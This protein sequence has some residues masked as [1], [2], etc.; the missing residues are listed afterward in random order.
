MAAD[1]KEHILDAAERLI[2]EKGI[3]AVSLRSITAAADVNLAAV[4]YHFGSKEG[5]VRKV[6][7]RRVEGLNRDRLA[8][9]TAAEERAG[10]GPLAVEDVLRSLYEPAFRL[11]QQ[12]PDGRMFVRICGRLYAEPA[13]YVQEHVDQ[14]FEQV[15][16]R[17]TAA[18]ERA[19]P[20]VNELDRSWGVHFAVGAMIHT[21]LDSERLKRFTDGVC[22]PA[23]VETAIEEMVRFSAAG[24]RAARPAVNQNEDSDVTESVGAHA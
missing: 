18:F 3:D 14:L 13:A 4:H 23:D 20:G 11:F 22:D 24:L 21:M 1:T 10:D 19:L 6:F 15:V 12:H 5:L 16:K 7:A 8:Q 17:F 9:L 2:S